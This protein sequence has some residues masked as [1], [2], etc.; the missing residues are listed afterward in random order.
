MAT[1]E[2]RAMPDGIT[3]MT[4]A[5]V[6]YWV[7]NIQDV[8]TARQREELV[9][10]HF[11]L[12]V[13]EPVVTEEG[14]ESFDMRALVRDIREHNWNTRGV[15]PLVIAYVDVGQAE[16][17]RWYF[18]SDWKVGD[19][20][21]IVADDPDDWEGCMPVAYWA[22]EW[23]DIVIYGHQGRSMVE[24]T[25]KAGFDGIYMDWVE[26][27]SDENVIA[28]AADDGVEPVDE[29]FSFIESIRYY[30]REESTRAD[31]D[32]LIIAQN[33]SDLYDEDPER[34]LAVVD[35]I[36][37]E[38]IWYDGTGGFDDWDD[39]TG[40]NVPTNDIY[41]DWTEEVLEM[42]EPMKPHLPI[43]CVEY[44][45]DVGGGKGESPAARVYEELAPAHGFVPYCSRRS[46][47]RLSTTPYPA[48]YDP[49]D[50]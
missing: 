35:A 15:D 17:W 49:Q 13:L 10:T 48:G 2:E 30:A 4:L 3:G 36:A 26:A 34:Y 20:D 28:R 1:Y 44:A 19:P 14:M 43:F 23:Q 7:Y 5:Q 45:Q 42:L 25:L 24:E 18:K 47:A 6:E 50:Y 40:Y 29:M 38:G 37:L 11:D 9:G 31:P 32:Y 27:F 46:L 16:E 39:E 22:S 12:Y 33:A 8:D 21:W 41:P